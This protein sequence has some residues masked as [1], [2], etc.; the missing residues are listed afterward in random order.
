M[1]ID[2]PLLQKKSMSVVR[3]QLYTTFSA[4]KSEE[5]MR[6]VQ[7]GLRNAIKNAV[8]EKGW[9]IRHMCR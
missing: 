4:H 9:D 7:A 1:M 8:T 2:A 6:E 3:V 5:V